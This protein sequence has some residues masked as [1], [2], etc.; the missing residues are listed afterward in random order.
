MLIKG[1]ERIPGMLYNE[2]VVANRVHMNKSFFGKS[3]LNISPYS[4]LGKIQDDS[5]TVL[6]D[7]LNPIAMIKQYEDVVSTGMFGR[8]KDTFTKETR[9]IDPSEIGIFSEATKDSGD[10]GI[11]AYLSAAP[12]IKNVRGTVGELD[13]KKDGATSILSTA[14]LLAPGDMLDDP[15]RLIYG[16]LLQ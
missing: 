14:G 12:K 6:V 11:S 5:S 4:V 7:D 8:N 13:F 9:S 3:K 15:K 10:V 2:L 16:P 1:Y